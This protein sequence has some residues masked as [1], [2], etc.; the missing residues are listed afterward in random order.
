MEEENS[1][2]RS[3]LEVRP[4]SEVPG[5]AIIVKDP[6]TRRFYRFTSM[7]GA[8][9]PLLDGTHDSEFIA[10]SV[11]RSF[12]TEVTREQIR[13]FVGKLQGLQLL[14]HPSC[15][16]MLEAVRRRK[17]RLTGLLSIKLYAFDP[18]ELL[19]RLLEKL[20]FCFGQGF[21][22]TVWLSIGVAVTIS[23]LNWESLY[24]SFGTLLSLYSIPLLFVVAFVVMTIHEFA[25]GIA[26]KHFGGKVEEMGFLILYL[27]PAFYC[28]LSDAWMLRK[29][30]RI[31]VT[32]AGGYIQLFLWALATIAWRLLAPETFL[33]HVCLVVVAFSGL[34]TLFN[35]NPLIKLDGYYLL[36]DYLEIP[37]LRTK[38]WQFL[39]RRLRER[40]LGSEP[41]RTSSTKR[42]RK[43]YLVYGT[44]S[45]LFTAGLIALMLERLGTWLV[46]EFQTWGVV[47]ISVLV[48]A[49]IPPGK[50]DETAAGT[51]SRFRIVIRLR[52]SPRFLIPLF[53]IFVAGLLPWELKISGDFTIIPNK[54]VSISPQ[55]E[56]ILKL[57]RVDEGERVHTGD[58]LAEM[59]NLELGNAYEDT[60]G[61]L[62]AQEATLQLLRSGARPEEIDR[63]R[64]Q[65]ETKRAELETAGRV[66]EELRVL[67]EAVAKKEV[68]VLN[69]EANY[70]RTQKLLREGLISKNDAER[71][72]T[73]YAVLQ[74]ELSEAKGQ[75]KVLDERTDRTKEVKLRELAQAESELRILLA[76]TR[77][78]TIEA[79]AAAVNRLAEKKGNLEQQLECLKIRSPIEGV[80]ATPHL[81]N[82]VGQYLNKG[83]SFC[84]VVSE[85]VV[86]VDMPVPEK[87][88]ADVRGGL[89]ITLKVRGYPSR[90]FQATVMAIAP[91]AV[92]SGQERMVMVQ[93]ELKNSDGILKAGMTGVGKIRCGKRMIAE[94]ASRR[95][96]RWLR[97][98][99][100]EY[101]P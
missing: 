64:K 43:V 77:K 99:F 85:G 11:S 28:N 95:A 27:I 53:L 10:A 46:S 56:G 23:I 101:L 42:E 79:T 35:F 89:P 15:W 65:I 88:I 32:L 50:K 51:M 93:G 37:N 25:H 69:A 19:T 22:F 4:E 92:E 86:I 62:A 83:D 59:E 75:L 7:Q 52:K 36:S 70:Q 41:K 5:S 57:I 90:T 87:E 81:K 2:L 66:E 96:L 12:E 58:V 29:R 73:A 33:S 38:A 67:S 63:A 80:I 100:W 76:G 78:E 3:D 8:V 61:E 1:K 82:R 34:Q 18:D 16:V 20:G 60:K 94:L 14:D 6:I 26:L 54:K 39:G 40:L 45:F 47:L 74:R 71:D 68:E 97:T 21:S 49:A 98:E 55:V 30:E 17:H 31:L 13:D 44:A 48:L 24:I 91:V 9:L 72:Q 84:D